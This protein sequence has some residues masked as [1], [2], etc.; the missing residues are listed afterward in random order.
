MHGYTPMTPKGAGTPAEGDPWK[1]AQQQTPA[2]MN[3]SA[4]DAVIEATEAALKERTR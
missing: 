1:G 4:M 2:P 3:F